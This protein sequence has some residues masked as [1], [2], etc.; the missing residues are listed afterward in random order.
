MDN[1]K[2]N[3]QNRRELL[4]KI[5]LFVFAV[6][7]LVIVLP[8]EGKF[9][10]EFAK[11]KP[12]LHDDLYAPFD[13]AIIKFDEEIKAEQEQTLK[14][15]RPYFTLDTLVAS[16]QAQLFI[17]T[18]ENGWKERYGSVNALSQQKEY[19]VNTGLDI[20]DSL[21]G[22]GI[23]ELNASI[24]NKP[25]GFEV[26]ILRKNEAR[27]VPLHKVYTLQQATGFIS[28]KLNRLGGEDTETLR[29]ALINSI[30]YNLFFD[31][32]KTE[33][34]KNSAIESISPFRGMVQRGELIIP[35]GA[36]VN[37][38]HFRILTSLKNNYEVHLGAAKAR[39]AI[40]GGQAILTSISI[41]I[42][43]LFLYSYRKDIL[44]NNK[45]IA[46]ILLL[47]FSMVFI[48]SMVVRF[49]VSYFYLV[50]VCLVPIIIRVFYDTRLALFVHLITIFITGFIAPNSFQFVFIQLI[51]GVVAIISIVR[52]ERRSQFFYTAFWVFLTYVAIY[53]GLNLM[54]EGNFHSIHIR[55]IYQMA[56]NAGLLLFAYPLMFLIERSFNYITDVTL[57]ELG[58]SNNKLL[59]EL[60]R[61]APGTF[62][63]S[64]QVANLA[65]EASFAIGGDSKLV[66]VGALYHDIGKIEAPLYFI[67][68]Q[69]SGINPHDQI[70]HEESARI[71]IRHVTRGV[72]IAK[73]HKLPPEV[74]DFIT[75]H[76][77]TRKVEYFYIKQKLENPKEGLDEEAFTYPGPIPFSKETALVMMADSVE[78]A[79]RSLTNPDDKAIDEL[80]ERMIGRQLDSGQLA[81]ANLTLRDIAQLKT[82]FKRNLQNIYHVRISYPEEGGK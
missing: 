23:I 71:I 43:I 44:A 47:I 61:K 82:I 22:K 70:S 10:Y 30:T 52:L 78:A 51:A 37:D 79:S 8:K 25:A 57:I 60:A 16:S 1:P 35:R 80:V 63:H 32:E 4:I 34:E 66:R 40:T 27:E 31:K 50:P 73:K 62:Q 33:A 20:L 72:E 39:Y 68:N 15:L 28:M 45:R 6:V 56:G 67:E 38:D 76:H 11:G 5:G 19:L 9:R 17:N 36:R 77:G 69:V 53:V 49:E 7:L 21:F 81:E 58:N 42:L 55:H 48:A 13:F 75:T 3:N 41:L 26:Y 54:Q 65:E 74:I 46:L 18:F 59:R 29:N 24:E 64:L 12:W 2:Q 14:N